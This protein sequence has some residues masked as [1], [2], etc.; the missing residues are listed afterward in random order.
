MAPLYGEPERKYIWLSPWHATVWIL[1]IQTVGGGNANSNLHN[2]TRHFLKNPLPKK[3]PFHLDKGSFIGNSALKNPFP[4]NFPY[5]DFSPYV[6]N[7][8]RF[9]IRHSPHATPSPT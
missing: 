5:N 6:K 1:E 8:T 3:P 9:T 2:T 4:L 7:L